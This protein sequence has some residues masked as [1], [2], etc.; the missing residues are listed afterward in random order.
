M[1]K[2][3]DKEKLIER[4]LELPGVG[5]NSNAMDVIYRFESPKV[6]L[7]ENQQIVLEWLKKEYFDSYVKSVLSNLYFYV[8]LT[9][10]AD[11]E[12]EEIE[13]MVDAYE[14][15]EDIE[16]AQVLQAFASWVEQEE[17]E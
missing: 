5:S 12:N 17:E 10:V 2:L 7:N 1:N 6:E 3:I 13:S 8:N 4:L 11:L 16:F 15:L 14:K 9:A